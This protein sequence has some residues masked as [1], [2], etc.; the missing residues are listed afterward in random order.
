MNRP[1]SRTDYSRDEEEDQAELEP[2]QMEA[3][4]SFTKEGLRREEEEIR[5][6]ERKKL[7]LE[8]RVQGMSKDL[9]G[10]T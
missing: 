9:A 4:V 6:L 1:S 7:G 8:E 2:E 5:E 3:T 10:L